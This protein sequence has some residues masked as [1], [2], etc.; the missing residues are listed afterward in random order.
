MSMKA[1]VGIG[2]CAA[3][4]LAGGAVL[5][6][7][8]NVVRAAIEAGATPDYAG[9]WRDG[10][11]SSTNLPV[12]ALFDGVTA[13]DATPTNGWAGGI[14][15]AGLAEVVLND[16]CLAALGEV[17]QVER[18]VLHR[19]G[20]ADGYLWYA[21]QTDADAFSAKAFA[22]TAWRVEASANGRDWT[23]VDEQTG[24]EWG[25]EELSKAFA[26]KTPGRYV[27]LR[28]VPLDSPRFSGRLFTTL[29]PLCPYDVGLMEVEYLAAEAADDGAKA[30]WLLVTS[31]CPKENAVCILTESATVSA[32]ACGYDGERRF[33]VVTGYTL[34]T[35]TDGAW[36]DGETVSAQSYEFAA[37]GT[38]K[39]LTWHFDEESVTGYRLDAQVVAPG[40][41]S[42][43]YS[44]TSSPDA[45]G[46]Y[47]PGT[48]VT[49][50]P[51]EHAEPPYSYF[52][53][54]EGDGVTAES[55]KT[56]ILTLTMDGPKTL[57]CWFN[58]SWKLCNGIADVTPV[59]Y[60]CH[61]NPWFLFDGCH[62]V[63]VGDA[64]NVSAAPAAPYL[65]RGFDRKGTTDSNVPDHA[66]RRVFGLSLSEN[67]RLNF[68]TPVY[69]S[70]SKQ[71]DRFVG[72]DGTASLY[73]MKA[74][75]LVVG[76]NIT[77]GIGQNWPYCG[78]FRWPNLVHVEG[79][80]EVS[81]WCVPRRAFDGSS[82]TNDVMDLIPPNV[83]E[84]KYA[85]FYGTKVSGTLVVPSSV[86]WLGGNI[87]G[88]TPIA[89]VVVTN[90]API[91][92]GGNNEGYNLQYEH[93]AFMEMA[94]LKT[95]TFCATNT[96]TTAGW[97]T[98][99]PVCELTFVSAYPEGF[100]TTASKSGTGNRPFFYNWTGF[101]TKHD[102][103]M[104]ASKRQP[105][106]ME[107][108]IP[109]S[110]FTEEELA[111]RNSDPKLGK[112]CFGIVTGVN[113]NGS[114]Q[115]LAWAVHRP[116]PGDKEPGFVLTLR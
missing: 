21:A 59:G 104:Y 11:S 47:A 67:G 85:A 102:T 44:S 6:D 107:G 15:S 80:R 63:A 25:D 106:W 62:A 38:A 96:V 113:A 86:T 28:F 50:T 37:D 8:F 94:N 73:G 31:D 53:R 55:A 1:T 27:G 70:E 7:G 100:L 84:I 41:E 109:V 72:F 108:V 14:I 19:F 24:V 75:E 68:T 60:F 52:Y 76:A 56:K 65:V 9:G 18:Y 40:Y 36:V 116:M 83:T 87:L 71:D 93:S 95:I 64:N 42:F 110:E 32:P 4:A 48:T 34:A 115:K 112:A 79:M 99:V 39:R 12:S 91:K 43:E 88:G 54:W 57:K 82:V 69:T 66:N 51:V 46:Y 2:I 30:G 114:G 61:Y 74:A 26:L 77:K 20:Y 81:T 13:N 105:G 45:A 35:W 10:Y 3:A 92:L 33:G 103:Y 16:A 90:T 49:V 98:Y 23:T 17:P 89:D 22:P 5:A 111:L 58:R 97:Y 29:P 101:G 78:S